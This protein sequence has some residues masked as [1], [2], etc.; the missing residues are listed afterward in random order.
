MTIQA[1][2]PQTDAPSTQCPY[3]PEPYLR[4]RT[5][6][7]SLLAI[8][9]PIGDEIY[10]CAGDG[11]SCSWVYSNKA[12]VI[13]QSGFERLSP[14]EIKKAYHRAIA[15]IKPQDDEPKNYGRAPWES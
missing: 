6:W 14:F 8:A 1:P 15:K 7:K 11:G 3:H 12:G 2:S 4:K 13:A 5:V 10:Y 9:D